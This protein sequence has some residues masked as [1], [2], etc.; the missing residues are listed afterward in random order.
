MIPSSRLGW[1]QRTDENPVFRDTAT[2]G[3]SMDTPFPCPPTVNKCPFRLLD[4][5]RIMASPLSWFENL[6]YWVRGTNDR[7][8]EAGGLYRAR[9]TFQ[10]T[11]LLA[12]SDS[13][14]S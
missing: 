4:V 7:S 10:Q 12:V 6:L 9:A 2:G 14:R 13:Q 5:N 1:L 3:G 8:G 11:W